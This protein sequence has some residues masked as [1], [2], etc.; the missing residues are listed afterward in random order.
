MRER[1]ALRL[2]RKFLKESY[3]EH[4]K[5]S[6]D[7][8]LE[9]NGERKKSWSIGVHVERSWDTKDDVLVGYVHADGVV[10]GLYA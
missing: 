4:A 3:P 1:A 2:A 5:C 10:E 7:I 6:I 9:Q 8:A